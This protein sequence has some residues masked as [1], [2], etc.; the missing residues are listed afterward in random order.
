MT[1]NR[2]STRAAG[3]RFERLIADHLAIPLRSTCTRSKP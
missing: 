2:A 3:T 1:R